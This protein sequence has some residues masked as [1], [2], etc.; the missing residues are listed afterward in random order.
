MNT[1]I[2]KQ[3]TYT[4]TNVLNCKDVLYIAPSKY[5]LTS[6]EAYNDETFE[7]FFPEKSLNEISEIVKRRI[8][9]MELDTKA[10]N[11]ELEV[12]WGDVVKVLIDGNLIITFTVFKQERLPNEI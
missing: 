5:I 2:S 12:Q 10:V 3:V 4:L 8:K 11:K 7:E 9:Y 6:T 1:I